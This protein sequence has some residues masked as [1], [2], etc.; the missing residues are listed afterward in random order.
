[1]FLTQFCGPLL[2]TWKSL[3]DLE[4]SGIQVPF[5]RESLFGTIA[6]VSGDKVGIHTLLGLIESFSLVDKKTSQSVFSEDDTKIILRNQALQEQHYADL[7]ADP[8]IITYFGIKR[9]SLTYNIFIF[10]TIT[11]QK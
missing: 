8:S 6:Q 5:S 1:M 7:F 9:S 11:R 2:K 4:R 3:Q 10:L